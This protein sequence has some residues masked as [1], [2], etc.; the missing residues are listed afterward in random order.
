MT[1]NGQIKVAKDKSFIQRFGGI[2]FI[3]FLIVFFIV[4]AVSGINFGQWLANTAVWF[5][6]E[7]GEWGIYLGIFVISMFGNFTVIFPVPYTIALIVI[8]IVVPG[9]NPFILAFYGALGASI[10]EVTAYLIGRGSQELLEN[11]ERMARMKEYV[12]RG[13]AP[14]LIFIFAATPLPDDAFLIVLGLVQYSIVSTLIWCFLGKYVMC[15][16]SSAVPIWL[17]DTPLGQFMLSLF[18]VDIESAR[19]GIIPASTIMDVF[20]STTIWI[21]TITAVFMLVYVDWDKVFSKFKKGNGDALETVTVI[22]DKSKDA[23]R[24]INSSEKREKENSA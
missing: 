15:F 9:V 24:E 3:A 21:V 7:Y 10:G 14:A 18:G 23:Q 8:S 20:R 4:M 11:S 12:D 17:A 1:E 19:T 6:D 16:V 13:W 2:I 22:D 5:Y